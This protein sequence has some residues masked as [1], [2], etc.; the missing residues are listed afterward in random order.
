MHQTF[1][2]TFDNFLLQLQLLLNHFVNSHS[3][4]LALALELHLLKGNDS[5]HRM[6]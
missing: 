1:R 3:N 5:S 6:H 4:K 2:I